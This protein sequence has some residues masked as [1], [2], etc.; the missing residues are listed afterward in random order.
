[1]FCLNFKTQ[2]ITTGTCF[3]RG[4]SKND[5]FTEK[6]FFGYYGKE[7]DVEKFCKSKKFVSR[8]TPTGEFQYFKVLK[9]IHLL[10]IPYISLDIYSEEEL[11]ISYETTECLINYIKSNPENKI[12][13]KYGINRLQSDILSIMLPFD[14]E[15]EDSKYDYLF[16]LKEGSEYYS[17]NP[18]YSVLDLI[19]SLGFLGWV[20]V[21]SFN[22][23]TPSDEITICDINSVVKSKYLEMNSECNISS[24]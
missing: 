2:V 7:K 19:C 10:I 24:C 11:K 16:R 1:M 14:N 12:I 8:Y 4:I 15:L 23:S 13:K 3:V 17:T 20:R 5:A 9:P 22:Q 18:D 6:R 21:A